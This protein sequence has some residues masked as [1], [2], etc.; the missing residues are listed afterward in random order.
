METQPRKM[1]SDAGMLKALRAEI[2]SAHKD[3][4]DTFRRAVLIKD[5]LTRD[6]ADLEK[7]IEIIKTRINILSDLVADIRGNKSPLEYSVASQL[8]E[9]MTSEIGR[10][11]NERIKH[12][13]EDKI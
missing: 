8:S 13:S 2:A 1:S 9:S 7:Q 4:E 11:V 10:I 3:M 5:A 6:A 12:G